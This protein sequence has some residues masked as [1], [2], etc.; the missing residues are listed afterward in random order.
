[1]GKTAQKIQLG[2]GPNQLVSMADDSKKLE[3]GNA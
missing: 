2:V 1:V 3:W